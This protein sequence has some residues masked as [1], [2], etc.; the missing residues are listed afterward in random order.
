MSDDQVLVELRFESDAG[1]S[2]ETSIE[3]LAALD[4]EVSD[5]ARDPTIVAALTVAAAATT[6][7][8]ELVKLASELRSRRGEKK[9]ILVKLDEENQERTLSLLDASDAEL[10]Q[11]ITKT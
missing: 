3:R 6:L 2:F 8:S 10:R 11:F 4:V 7:V 1:G 9:V 5:P